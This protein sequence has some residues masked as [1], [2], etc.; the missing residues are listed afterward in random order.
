MKLAGRDGSN[1]EWQKDLEYVRAELA[2]L[3]ASAPGR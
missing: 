2:G 3:A 1:A